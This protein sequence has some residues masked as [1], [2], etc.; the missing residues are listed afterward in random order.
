MVKNLLTL[1]QVTQE[2][3]E[4]QVA[5]KFLKV[6]QQNELRNAFLRKTVVWKQ[7]R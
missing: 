1:F 5:T 2:V 7:L 6:W 4:Y 3:G